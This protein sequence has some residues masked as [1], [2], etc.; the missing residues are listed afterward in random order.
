MVIHHSGRRQ[1]EGYT[2]NP[3][4]Y[5]SVNPQ[6]FSADPLFSETIGRAIAPVCCGSG[7]VSQ[8]RDPAQ[9]LFLMP[10]QRRLARLAKWRLRR[11][12]LRNPSGAPQLPRETGSV[13]GP[14]R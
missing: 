1:P 9:F 11:L 13:E 10:I 6:S 4:A 2:A 8:K 3:E 14:E 5:P 12:L 7:P